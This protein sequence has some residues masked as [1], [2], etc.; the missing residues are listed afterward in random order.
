MFFVKNTDKEE[1]SYCL[2]I[3]LQQKKLNHYG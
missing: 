1:V 3:P 2:K